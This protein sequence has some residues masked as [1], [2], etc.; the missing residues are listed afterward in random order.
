MR[1]DRET[2]KPDPEDYELTEKIIKC[3]I[4]V[5]QTLGPGFLERV[6]KNALLIELRKSGLKAEEEREFKVFYEGQDVGCHSL[7]LLV[8]GKVIVE[9]KTVEELSRIH[10]ATV[11]SYLKAA[12]LRSGLLVNYSKEKADFRRVE[13]D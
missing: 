8:E 12:G 10:Y 5:H 3:I 13:F 1:G 2:E 4:K 9:L 6:Y 7:D 11:R